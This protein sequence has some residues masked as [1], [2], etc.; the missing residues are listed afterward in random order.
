MKNLQIGSLGKMQEGVI[1]NANEFFG[2]Q[3]FKKSTFTFDSS[4]SGKVGSTGGEISTVAC[5]DFNE[6]IQHARFQ[7]NIILGDFVGN[8]HKNRGFL[9]VR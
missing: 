7:I 2:M 8:E 1:G 3:K 9:V 4:I 5:E 6:S